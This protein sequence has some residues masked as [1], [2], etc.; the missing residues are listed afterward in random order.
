MLSLFGFNLFAS[1]EDMISMKKIVLLQLHACRVEVP[2][3]LFFEK[4][5]RSKIFSRY[6]QKLRE[7]VF[8]S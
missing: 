5:V 2:S 8:V 3:L 6:F 1:G 7:S 4:D